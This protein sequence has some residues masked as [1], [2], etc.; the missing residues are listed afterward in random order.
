MTQAAV[1]SWVSIQRRL[2]FGYVWCTHAKTMDESDFGL[3]SNVICFIALKSRQIVILEEN[4]NSSTSDI[5][6]FPMYCFVWQTLMI[7]NSFFYLFHQVL[8]FSRL[9]ITIILKQSQNLVQ[10]MSD[11]RWR[12]SC[13][14]RSVFK[15]QSSCRILR[16]MYYYVSYPYGLPNI[17]SV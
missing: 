15:L 4:A 8:S 10:I 2:L 7:L 12:L 11:Y 6:L 1:P 5:V 14:P 13:W 17:C 9:K 3:I 16:D